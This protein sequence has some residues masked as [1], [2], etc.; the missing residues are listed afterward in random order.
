MST[1]CE[2]AGYSVEPKLFQKPPKTSRIILFSIHQPTSDIF[3]LFTNIILMNAGKIIF[4]GTVDEA[5]TLFE[6]IGLPVPLKYNPAEFFVN[7]ISDSR[8]SDQ[9]VRH[10]ATDKKALEEELNFSSSNLSQNSNDDVNQ[11]KIT[12]PWIEQVIL[13]SHRSLLSFLHSPKQ[14]VIEFFILIVSSWKF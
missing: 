2:L 1:L 8:I 3:Q 9:I 5:K 10:V 14:Y 4:H 11:K 13:L 7:R 12:L 6:E